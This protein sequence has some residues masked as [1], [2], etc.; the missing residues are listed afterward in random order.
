MQAAADAILELGIPWRSLAVVPD[1]QVHW[2]V[3]LIRGEEVV[4]RVPSEGAI[5][6]MVPSPDFE[7]VMWQV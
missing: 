3:E 4:E 5:Q 2:S 6:T 1:D 7:F